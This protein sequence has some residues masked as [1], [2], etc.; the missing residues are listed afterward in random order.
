MVIK[1]NDMIQTSAIRCAMRRK[2]TMFIIAAGLSLA[3][4][5]MAFAAD[6]S[7]PAYQSPPP[8]ILAPTPVYN[9][10]GFYVGGNLGGAWGNV[11]VTDVTT[12]ATISPA[13]PLTPFPSMRE[14]VRARPDCFGGY[15]PSQ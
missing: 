1:I 12:G 9:W 4:S 10:T 7:R 15:A 2:A 13:I 3:F 11:E 14:G 8:P 5:Q 6:L